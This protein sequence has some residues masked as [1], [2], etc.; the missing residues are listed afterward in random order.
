MPRPALLVKPL[1][2]AVAAVVAALLPSAVVVVT[3]APPAAAAA[4]ADVRE[5]VTTTRWTSIAVIGADLRQ[6][7]KPV[8]L[9]QAFGIE[10]VAVTDPTPVRPQL[11]PA[12]PAPQ[13]RTAVF[14]RVFE[15]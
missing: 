5:V 10:R 12:V 8:R 14:V 13:D 1:R 6:R 7:R 9:T 2:R 15:Q 4:P 3:T 11:T